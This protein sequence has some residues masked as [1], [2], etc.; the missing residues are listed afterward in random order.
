MRAA[1][2]EMPDQ[3]PG[4]HHIVD[5]SNFNEGRGVLT[6]GDDDGYEDELVGGR[7][8]KGPVEDESGAVYEGEWLMMRD[9]QGKL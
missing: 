9:G 6:D 2:S 7:F 8:E 4:S 1:L 5:N 3:T